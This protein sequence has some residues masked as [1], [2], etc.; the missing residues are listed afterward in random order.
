[1]AWWLQ[2]QWDAIERIAQQ[3]SF[4]ATYYT[5]T[6]ARRDQVQGN[7]ARISNDLSR[8]ETKLDRLL[9]DGYQ[10]QKQTPRSHYDYTVPVTPDDWKNQ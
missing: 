9:L 3:H 2:N 8:I 4:D 7:L 5:E 6:F 10:G 1:M